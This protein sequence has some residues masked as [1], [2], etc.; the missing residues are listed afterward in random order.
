MLIEFYLG[1]VHDSPDKDYIFRLSCIEA[2]ACDQRL[3]TEKN[4]EKGGKVLPCAV[5]G[6]CPYNDWMGAL[7]FLFPFLYL[8]TDD[9]EVDAM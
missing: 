8:K 3:A 2:W 5:S 7:M 9:L 6:S 4:K 1:R